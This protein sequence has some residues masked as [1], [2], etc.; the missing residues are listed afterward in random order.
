MKY[1]LDSNGDKVTLADVY[2]PSPVEWDVWG[3]V[4]GEYI[5]HYIMAIDATD[6]EGKFKERYWDNV[7]DN[8]EATVSGYQ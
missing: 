6:A 8:V 3:D 5:H 7:V 1:A 2:E 4:D